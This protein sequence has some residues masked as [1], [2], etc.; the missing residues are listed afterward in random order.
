MGL[1][2]H[3]SDTREHRLYEREASRAPSR[4]L[5]RVSAPKSYSVTAHIR[6]R[7]GTLNSLLSPN[8]QSCTEPEGFSVA[9]LTMRPE[10]HRAR[11][12]LCRTTHYGASYH[13]DLFEHIEH[14]KHT[15]R[16]FPLGNCAPTK[17]PRS[18]KV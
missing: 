13:S 17:S 3:V 7:G 2:V 11:G 8:M 15:F 1:W 6:G 12:L 16:L 4:E 9:Q 14:A 18:L 10:L 5:K